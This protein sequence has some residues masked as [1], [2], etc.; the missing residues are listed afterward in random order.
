MEMEGSA[1]FDSR[2]RGSCFVELS[3]HRIISVMRYKLSFSWL[4]MI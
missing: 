1:E 2:S 3:H 4:E